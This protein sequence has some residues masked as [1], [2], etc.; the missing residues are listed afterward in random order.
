VGD[1][2]GRALNPFRRSGRAA[3]PGGEDRPAPAP[4]PLGTTG[5]S[6]AGDGDPRTRSVERR[7]AIRRATFFVLTLVALA[8]TARAIVGERGLLD[9]HRSLRELTRAE[10]E[11]E[12]WRERN[13][14]LEARIRAL[15]DDPAT[16]ES[17]ARERLDYVRPGEITF[18]FPD[19]PARPAPGEPAPV[20]PGEFSPVLP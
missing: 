19:D 5:A 12:K 15:R 8:L 3:V 11:V 17:M 6:P 4:D 13:A 9:A 1:E 18:L 14:W 7:Q 2:R 16:I 10:A 20:T